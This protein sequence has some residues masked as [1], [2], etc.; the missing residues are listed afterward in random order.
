MLAVVIS[1]LLVLIC[2]AVGGDIFGTDRPAPLTDEEKE[3]VRETMAA[4]KRDREEYRRRIAARRAAPSAPVTAEAG[5]GAA[6][7]PGRSSS[8]VPE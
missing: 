7:A 6:P 5:P 2:G 8:P 4:A 1:A 3:T